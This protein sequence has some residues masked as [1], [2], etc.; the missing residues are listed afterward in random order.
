MDLEGL[1]ETQQENMGIKDNPESGGGGAVR[2]IKRGMKNPEGIQRIAMTQFSITGTRVLSGQ[3]VGS[4]FA[5]V[6][7]V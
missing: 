5:I 7:V 3:K 2:E 4:W 6:R 1:G